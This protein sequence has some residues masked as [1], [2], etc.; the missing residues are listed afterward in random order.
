MYTLGHT[1]G[2]N[3]INGIKLNDK[4]FQEELS[5]WKIIH[6]ESFMDELFCWIAEAITGNRSDAQLMKDDL[7]MLAKWD[8]EYIFSSNS[9]NDYVGVGDARFTD[10]CKELLEL[11]KKLELNKQGVRKLIE[12]KMKVLVEYNS[13]VLNAQEV[14]DIAHVCFIKKDS[15]SCD[16]YTGND[17]EVVD[18]LNESFK[19]W[20]R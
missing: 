14:L 7:F 8:D 3:S 2:N 10:I 9:T 19:K 6:T 1:L 13:S 11:N 17:I 12:V 18:Y 15:A 16:V 4:I 20:K 5:E